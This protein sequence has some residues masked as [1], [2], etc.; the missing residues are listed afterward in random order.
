MN[1]LVSVITVNFR[2]ADLTVDFL[3]SLN[4]SDYSNVE[5]IV[6]ENGWKEDHDHDYQRVFPGLK[7]IHSKENLGFAGG[8]NLGIREATGDYLFFLNND[9]EVPKNTISQLVSKIAADEQIGVICPR[10]YY[11]D[12][13]DI[14]QYAGFTP[15]NWWT[16]QNHAIYFK[17]HKVLEAKTESTAFA[18]GAAMMI[19]RKA[20]DQVGEMPDQY[21]L[22]YEELDWIQQIKNIGFTVMVDHGSYILHKESMSTGKASPLKTYFQTRNR[23]LFMRRNAGNRKWGFFLYFMLA[24]LPIHLFRYSMKRQWDHIKSLVAGTCWNLRHSTTSQVIGF[25]YDSLRSS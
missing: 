16:A 6:V 5:V 12:Q 9:T 25:K 3:K 8:N 22:Y 18:H 24:V 4:Q 11:F 17:E 15:M 19:A 21:F 20:I 7:I 14:L 10:I 13:P 2:Q 23:I 1:P